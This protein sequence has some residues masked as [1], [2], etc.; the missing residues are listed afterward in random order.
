M[1]KPAWI[2]HWPDP[3]ARRRR[4]GGPVWWT[5][6][7]IVALTM[8]AVGIALGVFLAIVLLEVSL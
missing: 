6:V 1:S 8:W 3:R 5:W 2:D 7:F 4:V